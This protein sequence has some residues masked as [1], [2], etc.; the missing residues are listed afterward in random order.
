MRDK[1]LEWTFYKTNGIY[2]KYRGKKAWGLSTSDL[3]KFPQE[4]IGHDLGSFLH[5]NGF[6]PLHQSERHD[7]FHV[8]TGHNTSIP[9]E[10]DMQFHLLGN[11][12]RSLYLWAV[13]AIGTLLYP[14]RWLTFRKCFK[15]GK[16]AQSFFQLDYQTLLS[17][18]TKSHRDEFNIQF[19]YR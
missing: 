7:V 3:L 19:L 11:G 8:L 18:N 1:F 16:K 14:D 4:S 17:K 10:V 5:Q 15:R 2:R 9:E 13:I 12:K 6:E